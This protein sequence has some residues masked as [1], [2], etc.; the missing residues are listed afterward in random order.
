MNKCAEHALKDHGITEIPK[1]LIA[2]GQ[3]AIHDE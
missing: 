3:A 2:K 1:E